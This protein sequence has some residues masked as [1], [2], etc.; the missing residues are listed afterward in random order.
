MPRGAKSRM[1]RTETPKPIRIK[2]CTVVDI[3]DVVTYTN[4][5]DHRLR[6]FWVAGGQIS[7]SPIDFHRRPYNT[8]ALPCDSASVA[9]R[10]CFKLLSF[11]TI[12]LKIPITFYNARCRCLVLVWPH[13]NTSCTSGFVIGPRY[14]GA[15]PYGLCVSARRF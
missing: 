13:C 14:R 5:G 2:F 4:F 15:L 8:L 1:R 3:A 11:F 6:D 12:I 9:L 10:R 7:P